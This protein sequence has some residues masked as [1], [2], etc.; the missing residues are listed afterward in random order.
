[1][2]GT[3]TKSFHYSPYCFDSNPEMVFFKKALMDEEHI[4][5]VF[6]TGQ[7]THGQSDFY[8]SYIDPESHTV[9]KYYPDFLVQTM[10]DSW[11]MV[12]IKGEDQL[13]NTVVQAK[14][15]YAEDMAVH[16]SFS[17]LFVPGKKAETLSINSILKL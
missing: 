7:L 8:V 10:D 13:D 12:E 16:S 1:M 17:Y 9:R 11:V 2:K 5:Q 6:F 15:K 3:S 14:K 4:K